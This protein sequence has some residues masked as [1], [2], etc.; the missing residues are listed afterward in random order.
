MEC[1]VSLPH[2]GYAQHRG[3][4]V[5]RMFWG[6]VP[7]EAASS[8]LHF[9]RRSTVQSILHEIKYRGNTSTARYMGRMM[10][11]SLEK[12]HPFNTIDAIIPL[13]LFPER[14]RQRG[15]NQAALIAEGIAAIMMVPI[16]KD[17]LIRMH[18]TGTQTKRSRTER[19]EN[20]RSAFGL[21]VE[22][23]LEGKT[24]LLVDDVATT[25]ATLEAAAQVLVREAGCRVCIATL[26]YANR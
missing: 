8:E 3:N 6:R 13:P 12:A 20:V 17:L 16:R 19:W 10:G 1:L 21:R 9:T 18:A 11:R 24:I 26:A 15:Y 7:V 22:N 4:P 5:E 25:G 14:E 23:A 2:T